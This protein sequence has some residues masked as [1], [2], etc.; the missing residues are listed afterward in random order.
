MPGPVI[1]VGPN[2]CLNKALHT[3]WMGKRLQKKKKKN[4]QSCEVIGN[5][6]LFVR[7]AL[8]RGLIQLMI[9]NVREGIK[10]H[11]TGLTETDRP[12]LIITNIAKD[13]LKGG[14]QVGPCKIH[15]HLHI[16][17]CAHL[18]V[19]LPVLF[20]KR[21]LGIFILTWPSGVVPFWSFS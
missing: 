11:L 21:W 16:E 19:P 1:V 2:Y 4:L 13:C 7:S 14:P 6:V 3:Q 9:S 18:R 12:A 8:W 20:R 17:S 5:S 10:A 15:L